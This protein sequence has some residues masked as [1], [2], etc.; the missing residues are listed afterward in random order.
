MIGVFI[1]FRY[2]DDFD[3]QTV[4]KIADVAQAKF[5]EMAGLR[6]KAFT[7]NPGKREAIN[8]Y[9][10]DSEEAAKA[11]F[12][13]EQV[14]RIAGHYKVRPTLDFVQ[15]A[16]LV[17]NQTD[18][19]IRWAPAYHRWVHCLWRNGTLSLPDIFSYFCIFV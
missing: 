15:I 2:A 6:S 18:E 17:E 5:K 12:T 3:E 11:F 4:R 7:V 9:V 1:T 8:F 16:A 19:T 10:W 13:D 14:D